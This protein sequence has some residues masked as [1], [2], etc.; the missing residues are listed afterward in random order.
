MTHPSQ[1]S[2]NDWQQRLNNYLNSKATP[3][4]IEAIRESC[5]FHLLTH[6]AIGKV[7]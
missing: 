3:A 1:P 7:I 5:P 4:N 6:G 2:E